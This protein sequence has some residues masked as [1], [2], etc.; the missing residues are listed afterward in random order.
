M[1]VTQ[2]LRYPVKSLGGESADRI[3]VG[4]HGLAGDRRWGIQDTE[5]GHILT[6]RREPQ[7]LMASSKLSADGSVEI[8]LPDGCRTDSNEVLSQWL[9]RTVELIEAPTTEAR[10]ESPSDVDSTTDDEWY[11]WTGPGHALHDEDFARVSLVS[12]ARLKT[13][14]QRRIR[15][16][17]I[18]GHGDERSLLGQHVRVGSA[19]LQ[20]TRQIPRCVMVTR[21]QPGL[22]RDL[23]VLRTIHRSH[24][25]E[26]TI[27]ALV[28]EGGVISVGDA[29]RPDSLK[30]D[31]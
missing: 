30:A 10:Y 19:L 23:D 1:I 25:G 2:L 26:F 15:A 31:T 6:A 11:T 3:D 9:G 7:L 16:N 4:E 27:G 8:T 24:G 17:I 29:V 14:D 28:T 13:W 12:Q 5:T 18:V 22:E 21:P 20:P